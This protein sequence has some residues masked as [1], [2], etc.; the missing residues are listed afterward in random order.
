MFEEGGVLRTWATPMFTAF[1]QPLDIACD[2]LSD[3]RIA[4]LDYE[5]EIGGD[6]GRVTRLL[7]GTY[8]L[9]HSGDD[10]FV[11]ELSWDRR[12]TSKTGARPNIDGTGPAVVHCYRSLPDD[13]L[14]RD[15][16]RDCWRLRFS[17]G[18]YDTNR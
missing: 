10:Q 1:D 17:P 15:E 4:Y 8:R 11:A 6:R 9:I 16:S 13:G 5:G 18:R 3:H 2:S 7:R 14:R 12:A